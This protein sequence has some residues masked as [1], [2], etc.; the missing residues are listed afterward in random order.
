MKDWAKHFQEVSRRSALAPNERRALV[1]SGP[2]FGAEG[3][4]VDFGADTDTVRAVQTL[5][6]N[7]GYGPL[8]VDGSV[9]PLTQAAVRKYQGAKGLTVDGQI[10][11]QVLGALGIAKPP[12]KS[13]VP[14]VRIATVIAALR[15]A[16]Q[17]KG[18]QLSDTLLSLMIGQL[19][20]AEGAF[21]GVGGTL[22]GTNNMGAA[23]VTPSLASAKKGLR[24][25]GAFAHKD[26]DPNK[27]SYI[28]WYWIAPSPLEAARHWFG[29]NWWGPALAKGNPQNAHDYAAILY[30]GGYYQ[31]MHPGDSNRDPNSEAGAANV[32]DYAAAIQRGVASPAE[33][34]QPSDD[35][36]KI[37]VNPAQFASLEHRQITPQMF[38]TAQAGGI[39]SAWKY[40]LPETWNDLVKTNGVVWFGPPI[41]AAGA[42]ALISSIF[43]WFIG[44]AVVILGYALFAGNKHGLRLLK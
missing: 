15:Q 19:R 44:G 25:W 20:G 14:P 4:D 24:G 26:S 10:G 28:G 40:L 32:N 30:R 23:Q 27:G 33:L 13:N 7:Q 8:A 17:E 11:P 18:Y 3:D 16:A 43:Y 2:S 1:A 22:G 5:L 41:A 21:P 29:D 37:T 9:G 6:N 39:G 38:Q 31:G 36:A 35:P 12:P 34:S 42:V